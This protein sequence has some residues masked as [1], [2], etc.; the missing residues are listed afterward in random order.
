VD[1]RATAGQ[2]KRGIVKA[3]YAQAGMSVLIE[4]RPPVIDRYELASEE[5][6]ETLSAM[7]ASLRLDPEAVA[8][9]RTA[10]RIL[11]EAKAQRESILAST[12]AEAKQAREGMERELALLQQA[13]ELEL[14]EQR[15][16]LQDSLRAELEAQYQARYSQ[17]LDQ[18]G[19][20]AT[21]LARQQAQY[22][23][24]LEAPALELVLAIARQLLA[25][26]PSC[27]AQYIARLISEALRLLQ[28]RQA[29]Q[30]ALHPA[31]LAQLQADDL[32]APVLAHHNLALEQ[33]EL[34]GNGQLRPDQFE[35][36]AGAARVSYD[37]SARLEDLLT[38]V[39]SRARAVGGAAA[40]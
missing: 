24:Q 37:L 40:P 7:H 27:G 3:G 38:Q 22:I 36:Q 6:P 32:L 30:L 19:Q 20:A 21:Q 39:A 34:I 4:P 15:V 25:G 12:A 2:A 9:Q 14:V 35:L 18:L 26:E 11:A 28:P 16:Q 5:D 33:V 10:D 8:A 1:D 31:T 13:A 29:V 17:A 23:Q